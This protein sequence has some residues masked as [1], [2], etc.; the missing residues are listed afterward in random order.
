MES[1]SPISLWVAYENQRVH[2]LRFGSGK[3]LLIIFHGFADRAELFLKFEE[4]LTADFDIVAV[5]LPYHGATEWAKDTFNPQDILAIVA[6][7]LAQTGYSRY[8][9]MAHS[10]GGFVALKLY[11]LA[12]AQIDALI[13]LAPGGIYKALPF[14]KYVF[15]LSARRFLR[16]TMGSK[17]MPNIMRV[18]YKM[19]LLHR[20]FYEFIEL[21]F[22]N[23][24]RR[25]R[26]FN[27]WLSLYYFDLDLPAIQ[28]IILENK[29]GLVFFYGSK[30]K[31]T[32]V[33]YAEAFIRPLPNAQIHLVE[34]N[35]FFIRS[36]LKEALGDWLAADGLAN[37]RPPNIEK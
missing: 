32:P 33:R 9:L 1:L 24:R 18:S 17:L 36:P 35:H 15:N 37:L 29:T 6:D 16:Y 27:S 3:R 14:N 34:D 30:D 22:A 23:E 20:S 8:N 26:L 19:R 5:D 11:T 28:K 4:V 12:A 21:H 2:A 13:L 10:M 31:I 7:I 25:Q